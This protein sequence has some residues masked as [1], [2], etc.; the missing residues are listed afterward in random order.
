MLRS[1]TAVVLL[2]AAF[3]AGRPAGA[4]TYAESTGFYADVGLGLGWNNLDGG[5]QPVD[6]GTMVGFVVGGGYRFNTWAAAE[7]EFTWVGGGEIVNP[8]AA[9]ASQRIR[10]SLTTLGVSAKLYPL[11][12]APD[13][14]PQWIQPNVSFGIGT[15][16]A[17]QASTLPFT[18]GSVSQSVL[19]FEVGTGID[20]MLTKH[21]GMLV[22]GRYYVT[23]NDVLTGVGVLGLGVLCRF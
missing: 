18:F 8:N 19:L 5:L 20:L 9:P 22:E 2:I 4:Q 16:L 15:G 11:A 21:W 3:A 13:R 12:F 7:V 1:L 14:I 17:E 6:N 10:A 23:N